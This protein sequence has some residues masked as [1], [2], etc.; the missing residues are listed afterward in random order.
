[1]NSDLFSYPKHVS[2][3]KYIEVK[4]PLKSEIFLFFGKNRSD[5]FHPRAKVCRRICVKNGREQDHTSVT[6]LNNRT[7]SGSEFLL[8]AN[9][10]KKQIDLTTNSPAPRFPKCFDL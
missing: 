8:C 4:K 3:V 2:R 1:M 10:R 9:T 7:K 6:I 5:I